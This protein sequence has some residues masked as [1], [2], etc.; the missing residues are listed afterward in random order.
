MGGRGFH[1]DVEG[2]LDSERRTCE[3]MTISEISNDE[4]D[5]IIDLVSPDA[6]VAPEFSN[7]PNKIYVLLNSDGT[8]IKSITVYD[9]NHLQKY[10]IHLDHPHK[11]E[12]THVHDGIGKGRGDLPLTE[13]HKKI[14]KK[15]ND[16]FNK[17]R[18]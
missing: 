13:E 10:S 5:F 1:D 8:K 9:D 3:Y 14:I 7:S 11:G 18:K 17:W 6:P 16:I 12:Y 2:Y 4:I 15:V